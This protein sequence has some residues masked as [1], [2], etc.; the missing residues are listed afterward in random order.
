[1]R[2]ARIGRV[3]DRVRLISHPAQLGFITN[4]DAYVTAVSKTYFFAPLERKAASEILV[5]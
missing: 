2:Q 4:R 3:V 1:V 5:C